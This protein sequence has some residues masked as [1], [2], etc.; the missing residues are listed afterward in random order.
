MCYA[1]AKV[2]TLH[3]PLF[4]AYSSMVRLGIKI[5]YKKDTVLKAAGLKA[6]V[7]ARKVGEKIKKE[8]TNNKTVQRVALLLSKKKKKK[9]KSK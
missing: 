6:A 5:N 7:K 9:K 8:K 1:Y 4:Q 3:H 2:C